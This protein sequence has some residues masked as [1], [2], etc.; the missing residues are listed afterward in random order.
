[1]RLT[2]ETTEEKIRTPDDSKGSYLF[3]TKP[4][5][6]TDTEE[7]RATVTYGMCGVLRGRRH[8]RNLSK[9]N[10]HTSPAKCFKPVIKRKWEAAGRNRS[11]VSAR[12]QSWGPW[13]KP[14]GSDVRHKQWGGS[15]VS[16]INEPGIP[17]PRKRLPKRKQKNHFCGST[18]FPSATLPYENCSRREM[19]TSGHSDTNKKEQ[20][21]PQ[22]VN[23]WE[24]KKKKP[25]FCSY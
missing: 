24:I 17:C 9:R 15:V 22:T 4:R 12:E 10:Q 1:M 11:H 8:R 2:A 23:T 20:R 21:A 5:K 16:K 13:P 7:T 3:K 19:V 18:D 6:T 25:T 14:V